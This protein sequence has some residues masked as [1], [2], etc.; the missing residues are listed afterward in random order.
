MIEVDAVEIVTGNQIVGHPH[1]VP[2]DEQR[3]WRGPLIDAKA[4]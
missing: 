4:L 1:Q 3:R 2:V